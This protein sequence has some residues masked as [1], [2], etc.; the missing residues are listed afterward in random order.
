MTPGAITVAAWTSGGVAEAQVVEEPLPLAEED[1]DQVDVHLVDQVRL[2]VLPG[3][4]R[5]TG[6]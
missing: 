2:Q 4:E 5:S 3:G 1:R 6:Q